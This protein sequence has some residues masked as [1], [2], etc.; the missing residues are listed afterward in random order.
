MTE[1][2]QMPGK[3]HLLCPCEREML[4]S[5]W[6]RNSGQV[7]ATGR[8]LG[9]VN[10]CPQESLHPWLPLSPQGRCLHPKAMKPIPGQETLD[11][12]HLQ[13]KAPRRTTRAILT[14]VTCNIEKLTWWGA[15]CT[16]KM[17][18]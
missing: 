4:P 17:R 14:H 12:T 16:N 9:Q 10:T 18:H 1:A 15:L 8:R 3:G 2:P 11:S 7:M 6:A 13:H 5:T